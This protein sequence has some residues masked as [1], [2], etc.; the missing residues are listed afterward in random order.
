[1]PPRV[2]PHPC[3]FYVDGDYVCYEVNG[4]TAWRL[5][6]AE[7]R[8][9]GE[10]TNDRGPWADDYFLCL[11]TDA[12]RWWEASYYSQD[13]MRGLAE[14]GLRLQADLHSGL[15]G[16]TDFASR[17]I[18]PTHLAGQ[19]M[20]RFSNVPPRNIWQRLRGAFFPRTMQ[21]LSDVARNELRVVDGVP[22]GD[23]IAPP[24][25]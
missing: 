2:K 21:Q 5:P 10:Y 1:M 23:R 11:A 6:I 17:I 20:L 25:S 13:F 12:D 8:L 3:R 14:L 15:A 9:I 4:A 19:P 18:W 24:E 22:P 7:I 16:S